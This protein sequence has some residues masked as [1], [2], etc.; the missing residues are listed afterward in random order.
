[1]STTAPVVPV[2]GQYYTVQQNY[3]T[4]ASG[5]SAYCRLQVGQKYKVENLVQK[6][7]NSHSAD[8]G[9]LH[10]DNGGVLSEHEWHVLVP[11]DAP[12]SMWYADHK[13]VLV[14]FVEYCTPELPDERAASGRD[15]DAPQAFWMRSVGS[16]GHLGVTLF[17]DKQEA[18]DALLSH[19]QE[20]RDAIQAQITK[21]EQERQK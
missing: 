20:Q 16:W 2:L 10:L 21:V 19:L 4:E 14:Q 17:K 8:G 1:M 12:A 18:Y 11:T 6:G 7:E 15:D 5:H 3:V 9:Y 13:R